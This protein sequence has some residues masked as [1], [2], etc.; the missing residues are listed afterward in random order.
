MALVIAQVYCVHWSTGMDN[1]GRQCPQIPA[2][3]TIGSLSSSG[4]EECLTSDGDSHFQSDLLLH[5]FLLTE[6]TTMYFSLQEKTQMNTMSK[7][8]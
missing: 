2:W 4:L 8:E 7:H 5:G 6:C 3:H 1:P